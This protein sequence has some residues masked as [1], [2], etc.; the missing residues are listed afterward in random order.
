M[1][2]LQSPMSSLSTFIGIL[3]SPPLSTDGTPSYPTLST[4]R[5]LS[6][7]PSSYPADRRTLPS[8]LLHGV[9]VLHN[10]GAIWC[11]PSLQIIHCNLI[12]YLQMRKQKRE[13][14]S[15]LLLS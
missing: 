1:S 4:G 6:S 13:N 3:S 10:T 5:T 14:L 9:H 12:N 2:S 7:P 15:Y 11:T 8:F